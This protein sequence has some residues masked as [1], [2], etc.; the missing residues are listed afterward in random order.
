MAEAISAIDRSVNRK[1]S[2]AR[3]IRHFSRYSIGGTPTN[4][5]NLSAKAERDIP[6]RAANVSIVHVCPTSSWMACNA[7]A[8]VE[9]IGSLLI[10]LVLTVCGLFCAPPVHVVDRGGCPTPCSLGGHLEFR[11][12]LPDCPMGKPNVRHAA[13]FSQPVDH[14]RNDWS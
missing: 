5:L 6:D 12:N 11:W 4:R 13:F 1:A 14:V 3:A 7:V 8:I 9:F 10:G 2:F